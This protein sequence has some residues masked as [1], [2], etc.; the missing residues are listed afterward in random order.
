[1]SDQPRDPRTGQ[2]ARHDQRA[3][4]ELVAAITRPKPL[5]PGMARLLGLE[6]ESTVT[7]RIDRGELHLPPGTY[8]PWQL[9]DQHK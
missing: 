1:M 8:E 5:A 6:A 3:H 4:L 9:A 2:F 7:G